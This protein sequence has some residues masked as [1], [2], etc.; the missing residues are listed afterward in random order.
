M[1]RY[2]SLQS[3]SPTLAEVYYI[4][5]AQ[6]LEGYGVEFFPAKANTPG[7]EQTEV[8][9]R[10]AEFHFWDFVLN[11]VT[12]VL[13]AGAYALY[14]SPWAVPRPLFLEILN[15]KI[16]VNA[17]KVAFWP[18]NS[19][20]WAQNSLNIA[21]FRRLLGLRPRPRL[22]FGMSE[23]PRKS[24]PKCPPPLFC[25]QRTP[26]FSGMYFFPNLSHRTS[27]QD[28]WD[29]VRYVFFGCR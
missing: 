24:G 2:I 6:R 16:L 10:Q 1:E 9:M 23:V 5:E 8:R 20:F 11:M 13:A 26:L 12:N 15:I 19:H 29:H 17:V 25:G 7:G 22:F 14:G 18:S 4:V 3:L 21:K 27:S 28:R